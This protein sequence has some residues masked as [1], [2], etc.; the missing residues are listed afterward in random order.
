ML[1]QYCT[2]LTLSSSHQSVMRYT[3]V[4]SSESW[5]RGSSC[6]LRMFSSGGIWWLMRGPYRSRVVY[7]Y[8][9]VALVPYTL[10]ANISCRLRAHEAPLGHLSWNSS[11]K[12]IFEHFPSV[13]LPWF[14]RGRYALRKFKFEGVRYAFWTS[15]R[16]STVLRHS[17]HTQERQSCFSRWRRE[18]DD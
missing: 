8:G 1:W 14:G 7:L 17:S 15:G 5:F 2:I 9:I 6:T 10:S 4:S 16:N 11:F 13:T 18:N 12:L 3:A